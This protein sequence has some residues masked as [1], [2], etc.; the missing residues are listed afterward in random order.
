[1]HL[2]QPRGGTRLIPLGPVRRLSAWGCSSIAELLLVTM[3]LPQRPVTAQFSHREEPESVF[4][5][6][7]FINRV[8][9]RARGIQ[10]VP[11]ACI[12]VSSCYD[13]ALKD[14]TQPRSDLH[15]V[16]FQNA[17][18]ITH[19]K[20]LHTQQPYPWG[21]QTTPRSHGQGIS[22]PRTSNKMISS[23]DDV[24]QLVYGCDQNR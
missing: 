20:A 7:L 11:E 14:H 19:P 15:L 4:F 21:S 3:S 24:T 13:L 10:S 5:F 16:M 9:E 18:A 22:S 6:W 17:K 2:I 23:D 1:M 8:S 12:E